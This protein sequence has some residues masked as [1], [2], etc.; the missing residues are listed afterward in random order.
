M[1]KTSPAN[2]RGVGSIPGWR[3]KM[4]HASVAQ[5]PKHKTSNIVTNSI[6]TFKNLKNMF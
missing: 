5:K 2:A 3:A 6:K 1:V 4:P